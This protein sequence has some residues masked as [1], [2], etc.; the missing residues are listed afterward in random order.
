M[1]ICISIEEVKYIDLNRMYALKNTCEIS[2]Y[3]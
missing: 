2:F 3:I 1:Y